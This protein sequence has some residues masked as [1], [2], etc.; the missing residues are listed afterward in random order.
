MRA[1]LMSGAAAL[2]L[3]GCAAHVPVI[4]ESEF[5]TAGQ[6]IKTQIENNVHPVTQSISLY[7]A[8]ARALKYNIDHRV[9]MMG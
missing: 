9:A 7:E 5:A 2:I 3:T 4:D 6:D 1:F 8:M